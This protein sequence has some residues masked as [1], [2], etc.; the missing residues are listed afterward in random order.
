[1]MPTVDISEVKRE[2]M[3]ASAM[4]LMSSCAT[5]LI[6]WASTPASSRVVRLRASASVMAITES[7][8]RPTAKAF[9]SLDGM[10]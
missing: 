2:T 9:I 5:W 7:S 1:M 3:S 4:T 10:T 8:R 6:S